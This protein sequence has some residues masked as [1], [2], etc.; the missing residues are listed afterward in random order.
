MKT[1]GFDSRI[2]ATQYR[3][4]GERIGGVRDALV[5][6]GAQ[7]RWL[8]QLPPETAIMFCRR[9]VLESELRA[10]ARRQPGLEWVTGHV[11]DVGEVM[12]FE[13]VGESWLL[14]IRAPR[15]LARFLAYKGS[16][17]VNGVSLTVNRIQ[18][19]PNG[20]QAAKPAST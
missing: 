14:Q 13:P 5:A 18:D 1:T 12:V 19:S 11:D 3:V 16:I 2:A 8:P 4:Q 7:V 6:A 20:T 15:S 10:A 9:S 17:T